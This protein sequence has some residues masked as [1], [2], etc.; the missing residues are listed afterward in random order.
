MNRKHCFCLAFLTMLTASAAQNEP[1]STATPF[2]A[3]VSYVR[4]YADAAGVSHFSDE[5]RVI[6]PEDSAAGPL[7]GQPIENV[8]GAR[9][10]SLQRN[11]VLDFHA[12]SRRQY[13]AILRGAVEME[14]GDGSVRR[15]L[16]GSLILVEDTTGKGHITRSVGNEDLIALFVVAPQ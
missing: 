7:I 13:I 11:A 6:K 15:F 12:A 5:K 4:L 8:Q 10:V 1:K 16:P 3:Q 14:T 9:L 2:S